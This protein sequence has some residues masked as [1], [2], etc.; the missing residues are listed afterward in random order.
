MPGYETASE[1]FK[2]MARQLQISFAN[3]CQHSCAAAFETFVD[4][5]R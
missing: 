4:G 3:D 1:R 5:W 2:V